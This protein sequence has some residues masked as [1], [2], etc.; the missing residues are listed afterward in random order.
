MNLGR[1]SRA[2]LSASLSGR[3]SSAL[4]SLQANT[5]AILFSRGF[6][7]SNSLTGR[8]W[9]P[10]KNMLEQQQYPWLHCTGTCFKYNAE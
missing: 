7:V 4:T 6:G 9:Y 5:P 2:A 1:L 3:A 8:E 10:D